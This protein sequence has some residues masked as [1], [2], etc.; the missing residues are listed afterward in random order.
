MA[1]VGCTQGP[2][3]RRAK[4]PYRELTQ[5]P[6]AEKA[7]ACRSNSVKGIRQISSVTS[8]EGVPALKK[9]GRSDQGALTV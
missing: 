5:V 3:K 1:K 9:A 6:L 4:C 7:K 2:V 8:G